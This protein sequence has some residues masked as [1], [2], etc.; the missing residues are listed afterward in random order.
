M[1][2][3]TPPPPPPE[4]GALPS[5]AT[6]GSGIGGAIAVLIILGCHAKG[7]DFPAGGE[8]ALAV[9]ISTLAGY[10]PKAGRK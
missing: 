9:V 2:E 3:P 5:N 4:P 6:V 10:L 1:N 7:I 8:A